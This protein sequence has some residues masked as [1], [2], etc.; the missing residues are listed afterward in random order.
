MASFSRALCAVLLI[1]S[2]GGAKARPASS[3]RTQL[4][5]SIEQLQKT[6]DDAALREKIIKLART[7]KPAPTVPEEARRHFVQAVTLQ[8]DAKGTSDYD[9]VLAEYA[10][11][12]LIAP[13][14]GDAYYNLSVAN[15]A[16]GRFEAALPALKL[17]LATGPKQA[18][19]RQ[20][21]DHVYAL[22][23]KLKKAAKE[24]SAKEEAAR[25]EEAKYGWMLGRWSFVMEGAHWTSE[26]TILANKDGDKVEFR[27]IKGTLHMNG[28]DYPWEVSYAKANGFVRGSV[29]A[30][31]EIAWE[32]R[33][34]DTPGCPN[35]P[36]FQVS[37]DIS[38]DHRTIRYTQQRRSG[39]Q[40]G[41]SSQDFY[42]LTHE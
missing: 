24:N 20:A 10:Q 27:L 19:A 36:W 37:P 25:A 17:F 2:S 1:S 9:E 15:E 23:A 6:P 35:I 12:L 30:S 3:P 16:A 32:G 22:E 18:D 11:A 33:G 39:G 28:S 29:S 21:Q 31:G 42:T 41:P 26:G 34:D 13:W 8:K 5:Q 38:S 4:K 7:V 40:C 14:W